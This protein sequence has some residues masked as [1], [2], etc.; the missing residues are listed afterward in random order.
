LRLTGAGQW[1]VAPVDGVA[2]V[3]TFGQR[4]KRERSEREER[5]G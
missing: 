3:I 5:G 1:R 2:T 4:E